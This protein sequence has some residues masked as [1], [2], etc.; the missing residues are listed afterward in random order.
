[1]N[2][3]P[4]NVST[5]LAKEG[6]SIDDFNYMMQKSVNA[7]ND[8]EKA[9][10]VRIR[11]AMSK[12]DASTLMQKVIP[13][14]DIQKYVDGTYKQVGGYA[15]IASDAKHLESYDDIYHGLRLD[16]DGTE[17]FIENGS[18]GVI[19]F[20][21][22]G[23]SGAVLPT[24]GKYAKYD[25]PFTAHGFTAG[26]NGRLGAPEWHLENRIDFNE[27]AELWEI[28]SNGDEILRAKLI[29]IGGELKFI[30]Q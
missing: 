16:Y 7:L 6:L 23:S 27:G 5:I 9:K 13:K 24:G 12:P 10:M 19:R 14:S 15:T 25:Y 3:F 20:T 22:S 1:L 11:A 4:D 2:G 26:K 17:F 18:C 8:V 29:D 21:S 30:E 28:M